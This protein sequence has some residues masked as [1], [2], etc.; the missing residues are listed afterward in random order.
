MKVSTHYGQWGTEN[1]Q[2]LI[3][4]PV[5][6]ALGLP[7]TEKSLLNPE[8]ESFLQKLVDHYCAIL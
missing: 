3:I 7:P 4:Y 2:D 1:L 8:I 6:I 5:K